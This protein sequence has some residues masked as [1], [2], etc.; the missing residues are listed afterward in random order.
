M[1][2]TL[3][4]PSILIPILLSL[5]LLAVV[6]SISDAARVMGR[7]QGIPIYTMALSL[8]L[9][10]LYLLLKG[11]L[12]H[13]F[14][15]V[16]HISITWRQLALAFALGEMAVSLPAGIYAQNYVLR[17]IAGADFARS[18]AATT[19]LLAGEA[20]IS[21]MVLAIFGIPGW[22]WL[23]PSIISLFAVAMVVVAVLYWVRPVRN[24]AKGLLRKGPLRAVGAE[25]LEMVDSV[26]LL[27]NVRV[28]LLSVPVIAAYLLA[29]VTDFYL[30]AHAV[31]VTNLAFLQAV[32]V[33]LFALAVVLVSP[34]STHLGVVEAGGLGAMH[35]W[36][37]TSTQGLAA[38][39]GFRLVWTGAIWL[40]CIP[41]VVLLHKELT[42]ADE[43]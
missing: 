37:Y 39:L 1:L 27:F 5:A 25:F 17:R 43:G 3:T 34:I 33:Y 18:S 21:M 4:Q 20:A 30:V 38:L 40:V 36:G 8:G 13:Y 35:A 7:I 26:H 22:D 16:I 15:S 6:F 12:W 28:A 31:G 19:A 14:M 32:T 42:E 23:R 24:L 10:V 29:L 2:K 41:V 9:A 11:A